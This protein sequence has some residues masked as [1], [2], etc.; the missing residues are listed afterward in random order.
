MFP[1]LVHLYLYIYSIFSWVTCWIEKLTKKKKKKHVELKNLLC[2][3]GI[4]APANS[5]SLG[6]IGTNFVL[7]KGLQDVVHCIINHGH[8][9]I[10][11]FFYVD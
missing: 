10:G 8:R 4:I 6:N 2:W 1:S 5:S 3:H 7:L 9:D 11:F